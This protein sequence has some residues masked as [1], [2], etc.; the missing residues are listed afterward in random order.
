MSTT[1]LINAAYDAQI[2]G[3]QDL[4]QDLLKILALQI[5]YTNSNRIILHGRKYITYVVEGSK[6]EHPL[7]L[8]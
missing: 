4:S 6:D 3:W 2:K 1:S 5:F 7:I 8:S